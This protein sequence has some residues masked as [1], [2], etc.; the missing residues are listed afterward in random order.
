[1]GHSS[2]HLGD[3]AQ[4]RAG[5]DTW[6]VEE[7]D[8]VTGFTNQGRLVLLARPRCHGTAIASPAPSAASA[9]TSTAMAALS[10]RTRGIT[11]AAP[12]ARA[13]TTTTS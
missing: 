12:A 7:P 13:P 11:V 2:K 3:G 4:E 10:P 9:S 1:M 6:R 5:V 8:A